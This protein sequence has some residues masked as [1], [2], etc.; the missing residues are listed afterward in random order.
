MTDEPNSSTWHQILRQRLGNSATWL[1]QSVLG[2][3]RGTLAARYAH[4]FLVFFH[5]GV[6]HLLINIAEGTDLRH[7]TSVT[8]FVTQAVAIAV[9]D[10][11]IWLGQRALG[12]KPGVA[13]SRPSLGWRIL[14]YV[15]TALF[16]AW[17][18]PVWAY[19]IIARS[20]G[21]PEHRFTL[22]SVAEVVKAKIRR[23]ELVS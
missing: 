22:F 5:S 1:T 7:S 13:G 10:L 11:V 4:L 18:F 17:S 19:P 8:F 21:V 14:G 2:L 6:Y 15:W 3:R 16:L 20:Q 9:E 12:V 23:A